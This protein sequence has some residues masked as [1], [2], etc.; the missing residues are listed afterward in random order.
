MGEFPMLAFI[1]I[2]VSILFF[3]LWRSGILDDLTDAG[4]DR[5]PENPDSLFNRL[6]GEPVDPEMDKRL[7][8][9]EEFIED[10]PPDDQEEA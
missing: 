6:M 10:L 4:R 1:G 3:V 5:G 9:F 2:G 8:I 7:E